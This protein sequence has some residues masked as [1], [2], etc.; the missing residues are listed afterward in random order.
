MSTDHALRRGLL[1]RTVS[2]VDLDATMI[3]MAYVTLGQGDGQGVDGES[4]RGPQPLEGLGRLTEP[5]NRVVMRLLAPIPEDRYPSAEAAIDDLSAP[6]DA[7]LFVDTADTRESFLKAA[8]FL[9]R[10]RELDLL[11][12]ALGDVGTGKGDGWLGG[13][14]SG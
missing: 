4:R 9:G 3:A 6:L 12:A 8:E 7:P 11:L 2:P 14:A 5:L 10:E 13:A 1:H